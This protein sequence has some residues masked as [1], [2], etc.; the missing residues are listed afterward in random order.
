[1]V[2]PIVTGLILAAAAGYLVRYAWRTF[3]GKPTGG[4]GC[5]DP[6][7]GKQPD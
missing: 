6:K 7:C 4:C 5:E 2:E 1:M 3:K